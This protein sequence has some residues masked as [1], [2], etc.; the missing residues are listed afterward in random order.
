MIIT[1]TPLRISIGGGG[2][3]LPSYYRQFGG[4]VISAA[5]NKYVYITINDAFSPG[6][7]LRYS[8]M[9]NA[10]TYDAIRH[11]LFREALRLHGIPPKVEIVSVADVP[12]GTG[13]GSSGSFLVGLLHALHALK[14]HPVTAE[15]LAAQAI[16]IEMV[17]LGE[18]VGKQDQY[19]AA[20]GGL[21][22]QDFNRDDSSTMTP[23][24]MRQ[25]A[26]WELRDSLML[27]F[28]GS[29]RAAADLLHDQKQ[30]TESGNAEM[31]EGLHFI[32]Q[33]GH[34]IKLALEA[35]CINRFGELMHEHWTR[36]RVRSACTSNNRIDELYEFARTRGGATGGKLVGAGGSGFL[37]FHT[38][39]RRRLRNAMME[40]GLEEMDFNFDF[41]GSVVLL[42]N[43]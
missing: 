11:P 13:L 32:K 8:E 31:I 20:Y 34:E 10:E 39:D 7:R 26:V 43:R 35:G 2:T 36:K 15:M 14:H 30:Q 12:A 1:R 17:R 21:L 4:F 37:L 22:C 41:D 16:D 25:S 42:R 6:Y 18:P 40:T 19:I 5:I 24:R 29:T 28:V 38:N 27:F 3:D 33:L 9:E 23:L